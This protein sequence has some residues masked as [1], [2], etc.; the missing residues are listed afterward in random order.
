MGRGR[1]RDADASHEG[2]GRPPPHGRG[3]GVRDH[4]P[5]GLV[6][7]SSLFLATSMA[8]QAESFGPIGVVFALSSG[9]LV[10]WVVLLGATLLA[11]VITDRTW[12]GDRRPRCPTSTSPRATS[13][14]TGWLDMQVIDGDRSASSP[15]SPIGLADPFELDDHGGTLDRRATGRHVRCPGACSTLGAVGRWP[16]RIPPPLTS[17]LPLTAF[18]AVLALVLPSE[19]GWAAVMV[20]TVLFGTV[21]LRHHGAP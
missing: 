14:R 13:E 2:T 17:M 9:L 20:G 15:Q 16:G 21:R 19:T 3:R 1:V 8:R 6:V 12:A 5:L 11:A 10:Y 18:L 7:W 4:R